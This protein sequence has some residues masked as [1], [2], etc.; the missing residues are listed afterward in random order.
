MSKII[1]AGKEIVV[2]NVGT[3]VAEE[4]AMFSPFPT[5]EEF[6]KAFPEHAGLVA[7]DKP[8]IE[9]TRGVGEDG[10]KIEPEAP[11]GP[12]KYV[13]KFG[14]KT[15]VPQTQTTNEGKEPKEKQMENVTVTKAVRV[16]MPGGGGAFWLRAEYLETTGSKV[17]LKLVRKD[18]EG[19]VVPY[20]LPL[21]E[22]AS[23]CSGKV[24]QDVTA[25]MATQTKAV[26]ARLAPETKTE[27]TE[28]AWRPVQGKKAAEG[29]MVSMLKAG[30][31]ISIDGEGKGQ[32][33]ADWTGIGVK[34]AT[35]KNVNLDVKEGTLYVWVPGNVYQA[36]PE[37]WSSVIDT[38]KDACRK[39][40]LEYGHSRG[41]KLPITIRAMKKSEI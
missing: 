35:A 14:K 17:D 22:L 28:A 25:Y 20:D 10:K 39:S 30:G 34:E 7:Q 13:V 3:E 4:M 15:W 21:L 37:K 38:I 24:R 40:R 12:G 5:I 29:F 32:W 18:K 16:I 41:G 19:N 11:K 27:T 9:Q 8:K 33:L 31:R 1:V 23:K 2:G 6:V 36:N 26:E